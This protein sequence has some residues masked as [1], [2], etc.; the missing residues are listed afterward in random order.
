MEIICPIII[1]WF[2]FILNFVLIIPIY[3]LEDYIYLINDNKN[4]KYYKYVKFEIF[5]LIIIF[6]IQLFASLL[7]TFSF[8][9]KKFSLYSSGLMISLL[10]DLFITIFFIIYFTNFIII[11]E[12]IFPLFKNIFDIVIEW[13]QFL[14]LIIYYKKVK[15]SFNKSYL[16]SSLIN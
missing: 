13:C 2:I 10:F 7:V 3:I 9:K 11:R 15:S 5:L 6:L 1:I 4:Y 8:E 16:K 12:R 14:V